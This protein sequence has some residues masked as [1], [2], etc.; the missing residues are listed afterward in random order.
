MFRSVPKKA[1]RPPRPVVSVTVGNK[2]IISAR[3]AAGFF[4]RCDDDGQPLD[5]ELR[6]IL[7][8][9]GGLVS[10][11]GKWVE[12]DRDKLGE[13][14]KHWKNIKD[15]RRRAAA[16][17]SLRGACAYNRAKSQRRRGFGPGT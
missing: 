5:E 3:C 14:L 17:L 11:K 9:A 13:A 12:L 6:T 7:G 16:S 10:L 8:C 1:S 15:E 4:R 2:T